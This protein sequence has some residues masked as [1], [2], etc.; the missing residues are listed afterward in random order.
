MIAE[1]VKKVGKAGV[2]TIEEGKGTE[3]T[4]EMV[5]GMQFDRGYF[6]AYFCTNAETMSV[7]MSNAKI[8]ITDKKISSVQEILPIL[9]AVAHHSHRA[10]HHR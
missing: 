2:I 4:I 10:A 9:Q 7:E 5:E 6:S 3:T 8:L 1:A